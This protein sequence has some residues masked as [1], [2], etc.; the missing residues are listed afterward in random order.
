MENCEKKL[1]SLSEYNDKLTKAVGEA[2]DL[3]EWATP[4]NHDLNELVK[5]EEITPED[6]TKTI[7]NMQEVSRT[8]LPLVEPLRA[9][10]KE[11]LTGKKKR[12]TLIKMI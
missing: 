6:R 1:A 5:D 7:L 10:Y 11:L 2:K 12:L 8:K 9:T 4:A 3:N